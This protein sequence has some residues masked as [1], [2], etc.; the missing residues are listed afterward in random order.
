MGNENICD[1]CGRRFTCIFDSNVIR[2]QCELYVKGRYDV[3]VVIR[4][5]YCAYYKDGECGNIEPSSPCRNLLDV[6]PDWFCPDGEP[7]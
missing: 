2:N 1:T 7:K 3:V 4:C 6:K 5:K